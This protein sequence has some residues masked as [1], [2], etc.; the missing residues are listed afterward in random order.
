MALLQDI[1]SQLEGFGF[2]GMD[3]LDIA[4]LDA[5]GI[6]HKLRTKFGLGGED[7]PS[8]LFQPISQDILA[9]GLA[10]TYSPQVEAHGQSLLG[11]LQSTL[12]GEKGKKAMGGFAGSGQQKR[13]STAARDVYG[14]GMVG[15]LSDV[16]QQQAKGLS[17]VQDVINKWRETAMRIKGDI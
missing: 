6:S 1:L 12:S 16:G 13:F 3:F 8:H 17:N 2:G 15:V 5:S 11:D 10:K 9:S 4:D 14:K 7:L